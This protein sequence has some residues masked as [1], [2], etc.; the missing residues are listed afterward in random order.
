MWQIIAGQALSAGLGAIGANRAASAQEAAARR[1]QDAAYRGQLTSMQMNEPGR[2]IGYGALADIGNLFGYATP[3][4]T[5]IGDLTR[6]M[7]RLGAKEVNQALKQGMT[8]EQIAQLGTL[9]DLNAKQLKKLGKR[10][11]PEQIMQLRV[12]PQA[13]PAAS[14]APA[15]PDTTPQAGNMDRFFA[16]PDYQFRQQEGAKAIDRAAAARGGAL[17][18]NALRAQ[19]EYASNLASGEFGNYFNRLMQVAGIGQ[20]ATGATQNAVS[21]GTQQQ[22]NAQQAIGDARASGIMGV[23]NSVGSAINNGLSLYALQNYLRPAAPPTAGLSPIDIT[24]RYIT[25]QFN[26]NYNVGP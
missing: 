21:Q 18:G 7:T 26:P 22:M 8:F 25:N 4:Y 10:L 20:N 19:T 1:S 12:G 15:Q 2:A 24:A 11:T 13:A 6:T 17:G 14:G 5:S 3:A 9:G 16:S 23:A